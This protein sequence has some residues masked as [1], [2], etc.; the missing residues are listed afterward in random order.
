[1]R[2]IIPRE[3]CVFGEAVLADAAFTIC[4]NKEAVMKSRSTELKP[5]PFCNGNVKLTRGVTPLPIILCSKCKATVSFGGQE[6]VVE[7]IKAWNHRGI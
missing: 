5:C 7:T 2:G 1:M 6:N 3:K 4:Y